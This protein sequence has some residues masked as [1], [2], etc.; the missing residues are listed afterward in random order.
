MNAF[1]WLSCSLF[2][3]SS[4]PT[5][6]RGFF[7]G[8]KTPDTPL[9]SFLRQCRRPFNGYAVITKPRAKYVKKCFHNSPADLMINDLTHFCVYCRV[10]WGVLRVAA[11]YYRSSLRLLV[12]AERLV[13]VRWA[14][15]ILG[16]RLAGCQ[17]P[18]DG[19]TATSAAVSVNATP[20]AAL[21]SAPK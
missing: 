9:G 6:V 2:V 12:A 7:S 17:S 10:F 19:S 11:G 15:A 5:V 1:F 16:R 8:K 18:W 21:L 13:A 4:H 20:S 3:F 14:V